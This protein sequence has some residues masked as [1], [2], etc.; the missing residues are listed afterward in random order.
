MLNFALGQGALP[1]SQSLG[2]A[3]PHTGNIR[4][5]EQGYSPRPTL[6]LKSPSG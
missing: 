1:W 4:Q 6:A 2:H 5:V 3:P